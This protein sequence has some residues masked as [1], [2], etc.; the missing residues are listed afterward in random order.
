MKWTFK[1]QT[2]IKS[3]MDWSAT[4]GPS[5]TISE[6][7]SRFSHKIQIFPVF[8]SVTPP[9]WG[10]D[11]HYFVTLVG[12]CNVHRTCAEYDL[13]TGRLTAALHKGKVSS[14]GNA[15]FKPKIVGGRSPFSLPSLHFPY[16]FAPLL[17]FPS[18]PPPLPSGPLPLPSSPLP[19]LSLPS[20]RSRPLKSS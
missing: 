10:F 4:I 15:T 12:M 11:F 14:S 6:I 19:S 13:S 18:L 9:R 8:L 20:L 16:P 7:Y 5:C 1:L 17:P 3:D 2:V